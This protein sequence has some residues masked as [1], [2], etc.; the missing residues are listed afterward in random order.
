MDD[1]ENGVG[2]LESDVT[3][4]EG[5]IETVEVVNDEQNSVIA[6]LQAADEDTE[7]RLDALESGDGGSNTTS[8]CC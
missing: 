6:N 4:I 7:E 1:L 8:G 2:N 5:R 3:N